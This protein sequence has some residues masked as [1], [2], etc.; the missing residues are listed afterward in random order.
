VLG[1]E[2]A[3]TWRYGGPVGK[4]LC[5]LK[6]VGVADGR[7]L[8]LGCAIGRLWV[9]IPV[10]LVPFLSLLNVLF[11]IWDAPYRQAL[12]DKVV[13]RSWS[14]T[15]CSGPGQPKRREGM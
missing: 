9:T 15:P 12:H 3:K 11:P 10:A 13:R 4:R 2:P 5:H 1:Y 8:S 7:T 14:R 6:V